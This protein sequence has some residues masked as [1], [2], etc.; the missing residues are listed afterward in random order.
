MKKPTRFIQAMQADTGW[1]LSGDS[2]IGQQD[3]YWFFITQPGAF[4]P[5]VL[6]IAVS[7][8][9]SAKLEPVKQAI[10]A[11]KQTYKLAR[12]ANE[13]HVLTVSLNA[14]T[15]VDKNKA[16]M[17]ELIF[18]LTRLFM[19][20]GLSSGCSLCGS[21]EPLET[22]RIGESPAT[23]CAPCHEKLRSEFEAIVDQNKHAGNY[24]TGFIGALDR[25]STRLSSSH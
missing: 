13:H 2:V 1:K 19:Q 15:N 20:F 18:D 14:D 23:I 10:K 17:T 9:D 3:G 6:T 24:A 21:S 4:Q 8:E 7:G 5:I 16:R 11:K 22:V 12:V 25:K